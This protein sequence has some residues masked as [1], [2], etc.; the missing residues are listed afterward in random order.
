MTWSVDFNGTR[1][2]WYCIGGNLLCSS[3]SYT[4]SVYSNF[5]VALCIFLIT[6]K[7]LI[8]SVW[9]KCS[10]IGTEFSGNQIIS[11][12]LPCANLVKPKKKRS[13]LPHSISDPGFCSAVCRLVWLTFDQ[14]L[15]LRYLVV[16]EKDVGQV[17]FS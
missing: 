11:Q 3:G 14:V 8:E 16:S 12:M 6:K 9:R 2:K 13:E 10:P 17:D 7:L 15:C 4:Y 5:L 1:F